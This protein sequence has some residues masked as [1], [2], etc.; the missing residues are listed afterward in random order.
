MLVARECEIPYDNIH[1][2]MRRCANVAAPHI[3]QSHRLAAD[4]DGAE[5]SFHLF[6]MPNR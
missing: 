2:I 1:T 5:M 3:A 6:A 4:D